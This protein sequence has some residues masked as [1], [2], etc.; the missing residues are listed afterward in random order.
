MYSTNF[1]LVKINGEEIIRDH[2]SRL[3]I[4]V[5]NCDNS[6]V[7]RDNEL[8][9]YSVGSEKQLAFQTINSRSFDFTLVAYAL[10]WYV[11]YTEQFDMLISIKYPS[12]Q[13][14]P[15]LLEAN[16]GSHQ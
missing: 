3:Q 10:S 6:F 7:P 1:H 9:F 8:T 2:K 12:P 13:M 4:K 5:H 15:E 16:S 14:H 11:E